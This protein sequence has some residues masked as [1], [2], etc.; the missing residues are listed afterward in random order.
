MVNRVENRWQ[1]ALVLLLASCAHARQSREREAEKESSP[2]LVKPLGPSE[3]VAAPAVPATLGLIT[4]SEPMQW[5]VRVRIGAYGNGQKDY[6]IGSIEWNRHRSTLIYPWFERSSSHDA[7]R[8]SLQA[9]LVFAG[10]APSDTRSPNPAGVTRTVVSPAPTL[11][12]HILPSQPLLIWTSEDTTN[13]PCFSMIM[14]IQYDLTSHKT[15]LDE[16]AARKIRWTKPEE[17][18]EFVKPYLAEDKYIRW[19]GPELARLL[20]QWKREIIDRKDFPP[21]EAAKR[22]TAKVIEVTQ[23]LGTALHHEAATSI[24]LKCPEMWV[25]INHPR[26]LRFFEGFEVSGAEKAAKEGRGNEWDMARLLAAA[27]RSSGIPARVVVGYDQ[28]SYALKNDLVFRGWVEFYLFDPDSRKGEWI[29]VDVTRQREVSS[30]APAITASWP[31]FG[32]HDK[33]NE[34]IPLAIEF[35]AEHEGAVRHSWPCLWAWQLDPNQPGVSSYDLLPGDRR[36]K[37]SSTH[38][39]LMI[40]AFETPRTGADRSKPAERAE[41]AQRK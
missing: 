12:E 15:A 31:Y 7:V 41:P 6:G 16:A 9:A 26:V 17:L 36:S 37:K 24:G 25:G 39:D 35:A 18:P 23:P 13:A 38:Q 20:L 33:L 8:E 5:R 22:M 28:P 1:V 27:L 21:A 2:P 14:E 32:N 4:R 30:R 10:R 3:K 29:P 40:T 34:W 19:D 11:R